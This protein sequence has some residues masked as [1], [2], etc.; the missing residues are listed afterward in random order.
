MSYIIHFE[1]KLC[2]SGYK[3]SIESPIGDPNA[4]PL[5]V[6]F[7]VYSF[8]QHVFHAVHT[9]TRDTKQHSFVVVRVLFMATR[10]RRP[11]RR[12]VYKTD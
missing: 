4:C 2:C 10:E 8:I 9:L 11:S 3:L 5:L 12:S 1:L 7:V 6:S